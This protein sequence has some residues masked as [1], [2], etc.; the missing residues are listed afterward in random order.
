M[1]L[2]TNALESDG[3]EAKVFKKIFKNQ[4]KGYM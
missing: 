3:E 1:N 2:R 4:A